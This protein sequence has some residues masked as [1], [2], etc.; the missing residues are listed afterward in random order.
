M[1]EERDVD[2]DLKFAVFQNRKFYEINLTLWGKWK[3]IQENTG[4]IKL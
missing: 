4:K 2:F 1:T 3:F